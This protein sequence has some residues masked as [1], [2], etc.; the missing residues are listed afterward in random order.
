MGL[1]FS[2]RQRDFPKKKEGSGYSS[3]V[4]SHGEKFL[5]GKHHPGC[6]KVRGRGKK[7]K[8]KNLKGAGHLKKPVMQP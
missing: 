5:S 8:K 7:K 1:D 4:F 6:R 2:M 3:L